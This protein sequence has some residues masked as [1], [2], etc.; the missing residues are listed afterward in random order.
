MSSGLM[1]NVGVTQTFDTTPQCEQSQHV[2][3]EF[4]QHGVMMGFFYFMKLKGKHTLFL[5]Y[6]IFI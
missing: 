3:R 1:D 5:F 4:A 6:L 2:C